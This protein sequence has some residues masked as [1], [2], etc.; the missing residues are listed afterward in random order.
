MNLR[1][2]SIEKI[3][4]QDDTFQVSYMTDR[5]KL[6]ESIRQIGIIHP[7][8]LRSL[9]SGD[10]FQ[11]VSGFQRVHCCIELNINQINSLV[12]HQE[13]LPDA[14]AIVLTVHQTA[15]SR[16]LN[17]IEKSLVLQKLK[18][19]GQLA[20]AEIISNIM[21]LLDLEPNPKILNH[22]IRLWDLSDDLKTFIIYNTVA[23]NNAVAFLNFNKKDRKDL[24][25]LLS[26][27]KAR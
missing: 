8:V 24:Y 1:N 26:S 18:A 20:D 15:T 17:L 5:G 22:V 9:P 14:E 4:L 12:Y 10:T 23:L 6:Q 25:R 19:M 21:P 7:V 11:I 13:E 16:Q 27:L 3:D 2:V